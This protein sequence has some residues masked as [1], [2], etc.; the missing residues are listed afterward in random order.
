MHS[1][2]KSHVKAALLLIAILTVVITTLPAHQSESP[3]EAPVS[4]QLEVAEVADF[5]GVN[6]PL[7][8][9]AQMKA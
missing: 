7:V 4:L 8:K 5:V 9:K 6:E 3:S 1:S 2:P